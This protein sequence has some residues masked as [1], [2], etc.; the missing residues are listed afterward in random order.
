M[1]TPQTTQLAGL[2]ST[3][4][5]NAAL[6]APTQAE[7]QV[8]DTVVVS[9]AGFEQDVK[10]APASITVVTREELESKRSSNIAEV[11]KDVE[12]VDVGGSVGKTGGLNISMRGMP[13]DY[14]LILIDGRRQNTAGSVTP[15][16]FGSTSTSFMPPVSAIERIEVV[17]G[18]MS[19]LYGSDAM[20]G[21][22]NII[23]RK[24]GKE[25]SGSLTLE[26]TL[27]EHSEF[28]NSNTT[29]LYASGPLIE[30]TLGLQVRGKI[31]NRNASDL[32]YKD[33]NGDVLEVDKRG[34]SPVEGENYNVGAR[35]TF[36]PN[37][38][39]DIWLDGDV[40]RQRYNNDESQLGSLNTSD[41]KVK[42]YAEELRFEREQIAIGHKSQF[43]IGTLESS[44]MQNTT[45]TI[46]RTIP[47][48]NIGD[49]FPGFPNMI[50]G[51]PRELETTNWV[52][53]SK[54]S[55]ELGDSHFATLGG[56]YWDAEMTDGL[57][58]EKF[59]QKTWA[60]FAEDEWL[61]TDS[62]FLTLGARYDRHEAFGGHTSPRAYLVWNATN[63][64]TLKG[65]VSQGYKTPSLNDLH[66]GINGITGQGTII[67]IG[68]PDLKPETSTSTEVGAYYD[69]LAGFTANVTLF[70]NDFEDKISKGDSVANP[71][72]SGNR[73]GTCGQKINIDKATTQGVELAAKFPIA[74]DWD[75]KTSYTFTDSEQKSGQQ[76]GQPLTDTPKHMLNARLNWQATELLNTWLS[77]EYRSKRFRAKEQSRGA[78]SYDDLGDFKAYSLFNLGA[79]YQASETVTLNATIYN[80][81]DKDFI[82]Y[83]P[84]DYNGST[85]YGNAYNNI[86][87]G[88]RLWLSANVQF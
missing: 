74:N 33:D 7:T 58:S 42:G 5:L 87:E 64:W 41:G 28:G 52:V 4:L 34:P 70:H 25:W 44:I 20:G 9:A 56:Q 62:L 55:T 68:N 83:K 11:L 30:D 38:D 12:G 10:E 17:R 88:R 50:V 79:S 26:T 16:G 81:L 48:D 13:S 32:V 15:N 14:T 84:F 66:D 51:G 39:H 61:L 75:L 80:L 47:G 49:A 18:P 65:G 77:G 3:I 69:N 22:I 29:S 37:E 76:Q 85:S 57:A 8:F 46:G 24:V 36:T 60:V 78:A 73:D 31:F 23:T 86:E 2:I 43:N 40:S 21:V 19:T 59:K 35:I 72:C 82:D 54:F 45:E 63:N 1:S 6:V 53:D 27:Q 67:T 71:L